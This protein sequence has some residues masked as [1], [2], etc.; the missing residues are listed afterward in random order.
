MKGFIEANPNVPKDTKVCIVDKDFISI[1]VLKKQLPDA[2]VILCQVHATR[3][4]H[5]LIGS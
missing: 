2:R 3:Y 4:V 5:K 1:E